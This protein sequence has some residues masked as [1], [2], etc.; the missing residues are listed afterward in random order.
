MKTESDA[1][2]EGEVTRRV[3][4]VAS[5]EGIEARILSERVAAGSVVIM[6]TG[7]VAVGIGQGLRTKVNVNIGT[8]PACCNP[9]E[10]VEK[11]RVA[12][13]Y[14][15]DTISD[16]SMAGD[17]SGIR[18]RISGAISLPLTTVPVYQA[19]AETGLENLTT[20]DLIRTIRMQANEGISS[21]VLHMISRNTL[22]HIQECPRVLGIVSKGGSMMAAHMILGKCENPY[23]VYFDEILTIAKKYDIILSLGNTMRSGCISDARDLLQVEEM[24][25]NI[26]L[27]NRAHEEGVQVIIEGVGGHVH[28][29]MISGYITDY[30]RKMPYPL[31]VAGP[32]PTDIAMGYDH[33]AG[34]VG[35]SLAAGAGADYLCY[36]TPAEH[37]GLPTRAEV[38]EGLIA[39]RIAAHIGDTIK[40]GS[41]AKDEALARRRAALDWK[42]QAGLAL[43]P[44]RAGVENPQGM[45]CSMCGPFCAIRVMRKF[46][47]NGLP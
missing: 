43:D 34:C 16:L 13:K 41:V 40:Y 21:L 15:A 36:L 32:L 30:K 47:N 39:F 11:A 45:P 26:S 18:K 29:G 22:R 5:D 44:E 10:E 23:L 46:C 20:D 27:A 24:Q 35:A 28:A 1:A 37:I 4:E 2:R 14:G 25:A 12:E 3:E 31:F 8:S 19:V 6:H 42:G 9:D 33:I 7:K 17:I 38:K